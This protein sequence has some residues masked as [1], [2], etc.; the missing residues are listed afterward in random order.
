MSRSNRRRRRRRFALLFLAV[1]VVILLIR[2]RSGDSQDRFAGLR[3]LIIKLTRAWNLRVPWYTLPYWVALVNF[4]GMRMLLRD[5]NLYDTQ[6]LPAVDPKVERPQ[7]T[8]HLYVRSADGTYNDLSVPRMG[9]AGTRFGRNFPLAFT[10]PNDEKLLTPNPRMVSQRLLT[11]DEFQPATILNTLAAAWLQ[12]MVHDWISH[13]KNDGSRLIEVPLADDDPWHE[14]PM[15]VTRTAADPSRSAA[16]RGLPPTY[17]NTETHWWDGSQIYG[18]TQEIQDRVRAHEDGMLALVDGKRLPVDPATG[19]EITGV[20]GNWWLGLSIMHTLFSREHNAICAMLKESY[21]GWDDDALFDRARLV[22]CALMAKIHTVEWTPGILATRALNTA[23]RSNW[24]GIVGEDLYRKVGRISRSET[25]SGILGSP[26][27]HHGALYTLTEEFTAVYRMHPLIPDDYSMRAAASDGLLADLTFRDIAGANV[28]AQLDGLNMVDAIY[29]FA[30]SHPG[31]VTLHNYPRFLQTLQK[32]ESDRIVDLAAVDILRDRERGVPRY[33]QFRQLLHMPPVRTFD[34]L[35]DNLTWAAELREVYE[36]RIEDVDLMVGLYAETPPP[37]FGFSDTAFRI[38]IL[39]A[40]RRLKSDRFF[41]TDYT[42]AIYTPEGMAWIDDNSMS[43]V[44]LRH[45]PE[46][47]PMLNQVDN[48]FAP[49][50]R[51]AIT[52]EHEDLATH[53]VG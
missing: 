10:Y 33:N 12:F 20:N 25:V 24:W 48:A 1:G 23:M 9:S 36:G 35:T 49:W 53:V 37:G 16:D 21:P 27:D 19:L 44:L 47:A 51:A 15:T 4:I 42:P 28:A 22:N 50:P 30:T 17:V 2:G 31:A 34:E 40:S 14:R 18:S 39:M 6:T 32:Q 3:D 46:L 5:Q 38:F 41:T 7:E 26:T 29:S 43:T 52:G 8:R 45:H 13:G 11:R